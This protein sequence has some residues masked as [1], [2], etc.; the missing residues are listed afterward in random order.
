MRP[1]ITQGEIEMLKRDLDMPG[2]QNLVGIDVYETLHLLEMRR[3][4]AKLELTKRAL[5]NKD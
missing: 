2:E 5:E 4:T 1:L 3:Q